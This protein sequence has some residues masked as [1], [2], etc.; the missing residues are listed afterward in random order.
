MQSSLHER[1]E[2]KQTV[3]FLNISLSIKSITSRHNRPFEDIHDLDGT[4]TE[5]EC[6]ISDQHSYGN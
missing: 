4:K 3:V 2:N 5:I 1:K 6:D